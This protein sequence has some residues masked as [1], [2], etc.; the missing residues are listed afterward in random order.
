[1]LAFR[2]TYPTT[3]TIVLEDNYR[4]TQPILD[5]A[6]AI[7][8]Q[9]D[10]RLIKRDANLTKNLRAR[11]KLTSG[12][13]QHLIYPTREQ[14]MSA[15]AQH[16]QQEYQQ[17]AQ[18]SVAVLARQH[19][20][21]RELSALLTKL[22][23]PVAYEQQ[24]NALDQPLVQQLTLLANLIWAIGEG[25]NPLVNYYLAQLL[26]HPVWQV[27]DETL[28]QLALHNNA[29]RTSSGLQAQ[30]LESL[31]EHEDTQL[32]TIAKWLLWLS[33]EAYQ[34]P[35]AVIWEYMLG[36]KAGSH[37][38][39]PLREYFLA[40]QRISNEYLVGLSALHTIQA[41]V[42]E[43]KATPGEQVQLGD[44]VALMQLHQ[45]LNKPITDESW[46]VSGDHAVELMTV[47]KAKG[48]EFD[49]VFVLDLIEDNWRPRHIGRKP[50]ANLPLQPYGEQYDDYVRLLYV[51]ATRAKRSLIV[52]SYQ[53]DGKSKP[54]LAS[55]LIQGLPSEKA[56]D[57]DSPIPVL[58]AALSW[59]RLETTDE[60]AL[61]KRRLQNYQLSATALL[62]FLDVSTGGPQQF[63]E[64][65]LLRLP[66]PVSASMAFGTAIHY[67]LQTAQLLV[68]K[69]RLNM[70]IVRQAYETSLF[71]QQLSQ[72]DR[73]R[74]HQHGLK[75]L[76][77]LLKDTDFLSLQPGGQP[78]VE[79]RDLT[80]GQAKLAGKFDL[81]NVV[82]SDLL[83]TDYKTGIPLT[84][85][86]T[87]DQTKAIKA[88]RHR[89]QLLFYT[90]L[91]RQS[92]RFKA[93]TIQAQ[94][95]YV[96]AETP[97]ELRLIL[98][99]D[100]ASLERL[101]KLI[102]AAW[103]HISSLDLPDTRHYSD[104]IVGITAFEDDLIDGKI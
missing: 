53:L 88:W 9:A 47:H 65:H 48:L 15:I 60:K 73:T 36:L 57:N 20:S 50:P 85:F 39:S 17:A 5:T 38:T 54:V 68:N 45:S 66:E 58:E 59:P 25:N 24:N 42:H 32:V 64:R 97:G 81:I 43:L 79:A 8:E 21:L 40:H 28:W 74:Y 102:A 96:E 75:L 3:T 83:I 98:A 34:E 2:R 1:M 91:A 10:D 100:E 16:I 35:L 92:G 56:S 44:F 30:W 99:Q 93:R 70:P 31:L 61:L 90:L 63:L 89:N 52:S 22:Q 4:S 12:T 23:V 51:A 87:R 82:G 18:S 13:I 77:R 62:Q 101:Q 6:T 33:R 76:K 27:S 95:L 78:E 14:Q 80:L 55:P 7:I 49:T 86:T 37:M 11:T 29:A 19:S 103:Q 41:A 69:G 46:F 71:E 67:A 72:A 94:M 104:D 26:R 84:S